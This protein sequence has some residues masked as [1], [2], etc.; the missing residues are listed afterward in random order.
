MSLCVSS[1]ESLSLMITGDST[2][3]FRK[4]YLSQEGK[5]LSSIGGCD[6]FLFSGC[7]KVSLGS[8]STSITYFGFSSISSSRSES[9]D[10]ETEVVIISLIGSIV[11]GCS[12]E[13]FNARSTEMWRVSFPNLM[14]RYPILGTCLRRALMGCPIRKSKLRSSKT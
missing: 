6:G 7:S 12:T 11:G 14:F 10:L 8:S 13:L 1:S 5:G 2:S 4:A 9:R 3:L